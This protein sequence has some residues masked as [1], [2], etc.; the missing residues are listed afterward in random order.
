[1]VINALRLEPLRAL[2][3]KMK[4]EPVRRPAPV[5]QAPAAVPK[6]D[7]RPS[8]PR[9][10]TGTWG[11]VDRP[12]VEQKLTA[13]GRALRT[14]ADAHEGKYPMTLQA[15]VQENLLK[16][17]DLRPIDIP[18]PFHYSGQNLRLPLAPQIIV[19]FDLIGFDQQ[20]T[21]LFGDGHVET[22]RLSRWPEISRASGVAKMETRQKP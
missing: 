9:P 3:V 20:R 17:E 2:P 12:A 15:L 10:G 13:I 16:T 4:A 6:T 18:S 7:N 1:V 14:Y 19:A 22:V 5:V 21:A 11:T 8:S